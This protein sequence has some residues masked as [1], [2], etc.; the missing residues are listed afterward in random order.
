V[1]KAKTGENSPAPRVPRHVAIIMDGNGRWAKARGLPRLEGHRRGAETARKI[2]E[3]ADQ[4][5]VEIVTLYAFSTENWQRPADEVKG[6]MIILETFL[7]AQRA[8]MIK[9]QTRL[10]VIGD[11]SKLPESTRAEL[12]KSLETTKDFSRR[13]LVLALNYS[14]RDEMTRV[15]NRLIAA[16]NPVTWESIAGNLDTAGLPDP[17]LILRS[18]GE[19]RLSNFL[20]LQAAYSELFFSPTPWPEFTEEEFENIIREFSTRERRFGK[21]GE[22]VKA[23]GVT[24]AGHTA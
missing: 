8:Y 10:Q 11:L 15:T 2:L 24:P 7:K 18:S 14:A 17:D 12:G 21:T 22:Q 3:K 4:L 20:M 5:G 19:M 1:L 23:D 13:T 6:L 16:G 9:K